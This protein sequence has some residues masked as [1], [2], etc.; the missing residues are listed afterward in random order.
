MARDCYQT[1]TFKRIEK[2]TSTLQLSLNNT[3]ISKSFTALKILMIFSFIREQD[4]VLT[5]M[6]KSEINKILATQKEDPWK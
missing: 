3:W 1:I 4:D 5:I 2:N 6:I